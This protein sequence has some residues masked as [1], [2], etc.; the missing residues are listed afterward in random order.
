[1][2]SLST[3]GDMPLSNIGLSYLISLERLKLAFRKQELCK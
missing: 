1:M 3:G 2:V